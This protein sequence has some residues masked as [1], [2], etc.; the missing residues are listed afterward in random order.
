MTIIKQAASR[1]NDLRDVAL[2]ILAD[3]ACAAV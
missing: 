2:D 3:F 1:W